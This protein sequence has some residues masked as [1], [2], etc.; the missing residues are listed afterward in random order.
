MTWVK[1]CGVTSVEDAVLARDLGADAIGLNF[2]VGSPR[3]LAEE[4]ARRIV[5]AVGTSLEI[6]GVV[7]DMT[8]AGALR[9]RVGFATLQ[10]HGGEAESAV[11]ALLPGAY[12]AVRVGGAADVEQARRMPGDRVLVDARVA[13]VLGGSGVRLELALVR[14]LCRERSVIVAGGLT[15]ENVAE[16]IAEVSP[17]GVDVASGVESAPGKKDAARVAAFV[18]ASK[19]AA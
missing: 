8:D 15:P 3:K 2:V 19:G 9:Q 4:D 5:G 7:A 11:A 10:L 14:E 1:I 16:V 18:R 12:K 13:G 6:V 17:W